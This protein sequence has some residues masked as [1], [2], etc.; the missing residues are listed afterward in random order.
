MPIINKQGT[1]FVIDESKI[2]QKARTP[3]VKNGLYAAIYSEFLG[4]VENPKYLHLTSIQ[5]F[6]KLNEFAE[7]WLKDRGF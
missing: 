5:K 3:A 1:L 4:A 6:N 2:S 7:K